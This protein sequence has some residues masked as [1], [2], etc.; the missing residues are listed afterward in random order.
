MLEGLGTAASSLQVMIQCRG[1]AGK[2]GAE[3]EDP[4]ARCF[5]LQLDH[6][7]IIPN[8]PEINLKTGRTNPTTKG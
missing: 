5:T 7:E 2:V 8:T 6:S 1:C 3:Q 4:R